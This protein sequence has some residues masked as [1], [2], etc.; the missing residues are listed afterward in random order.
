LFLIKARTL[1]SFAIC[2]TLLVCAVTDART[3]GQKEKK[4]QND[5]KALTAETVAETAVYLYG[6]RE[7]LTNVRVNGIE[8]A[9]ITLP[10]AN[11]DLQGQL[12]TRFVRKDKSWL[13]FKRIDLVLQGSDSLSIGFNGAKLWSTLNGLQIDPRPEQAKTFQASLIHSY[14]SLLRY[15]EDASKVELKGQQAVKGLDCHVLVMTHEDGSQ[16]TFFISTKTFHVLHADYE[17]KLIG[18]TPT[19]FRISY[20]DYKPIQNTFVPMRTEVY[21]NGRLSQRIVTTS[22]NFNIVLEDDVFNHG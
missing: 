7:A 8:R 15:R 3:K 21:E 18:D 19:K 11:G 14:T 6:G 20:Y 10:T 13:D 2:L 16:T 12:I 17:L 4:V 5:Q 1:L 22:I 9:N